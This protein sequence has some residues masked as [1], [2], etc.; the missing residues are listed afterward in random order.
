MMTLTFVSVLVWG[1]IV[2]PVLAQRRPWTVEGFRPERGD[3]TTLTFRPNGHEGLRFA[4]GQYEWLT[5]GKSPFSVTSHPFS[6]SSSGDDAAQLAMS[7]K[8]LGDFTRTVAQ[9]KL[10]ATAYL[11]G[12]HGVFTPDQYQ[13]P[14]VLF[15]RRWC[16]YHTGGKHSSHLRRPRRQAPLSATGTGTTRP[17][18]RCWTS[19]PGGWIS[20][21]SMCSPI[22]PR[23]GTAKPAESTRLCCVVTLARAASDGNTSSA[24][25]PP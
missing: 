25:R 21:W 24:D 8:A 10:G 23:A 19:S 7:I 15:H 5:V 13:G 11:D 3:T 12:P 17:S 22:R 9:T 4:P 2:K 1:R 6:F 18:A 14:W 16:R 20:P